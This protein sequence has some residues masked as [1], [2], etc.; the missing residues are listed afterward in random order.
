[1]IVESWL[2]EVADNRSRGTIFSIYVTINMAASTLGQLAMSVTGRHRLCAVRRRRDQLH[3][4][5]AAERADLDAAAAAAAVGAARCRAALPDLAGGGDRELFGA[6]WPTA[7]SARWRRSMAIKQGLDAAGIA[8]LFSVTAILGALAQIPA[9]RLQRQDRPAAGDGRCSRGVAALVGLLIVLINPR[10][11]LVDVC[12]VRDLRVF[13]LSDLCD[14]GGACERLR[15]ATATSRK[16]A[17]GMLLIA[18]R[19]ARHRAGDRVAG[20]ERVA[21]GRAVHRHRDVPRRAGDH[22]VPAHA[23]AARRAMRARASRSGRW[24]RTR[25]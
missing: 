21:A 14:R 24:R 9:G 23:G 20:D 17:G 18:R 11:G 10:A 13:G 16:V 1:M 15:Q 7:R 4:R 5:R 22:G 6:A 12:A 2:N 25:P 3:L 8:F 19:R